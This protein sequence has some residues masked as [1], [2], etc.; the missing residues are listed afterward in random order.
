MSVESFTAAS[1]YLTKANIIHPGSA[2]QKTTAEGEARAEL[3][4]RRG[5]TVTGGTIK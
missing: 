1:A 3:S 4:A 5:L 2:A